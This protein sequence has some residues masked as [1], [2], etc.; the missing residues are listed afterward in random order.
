M[1]SCLNEAVADMNHQLGQ[2]ISSQALEMAKLQEQGIVD[3][4]DFE[5]Y[6]DVLNAWNDYYELSCDGTGI[7]LFTDFR[8]P[9]EKQPTF[10][11]ACKLGL[12]V[13]RIKDIVR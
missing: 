2:L 4:K 8:V 6:L 7:K 3:K 9:P 13:H 10:V 11:A 12:L 5:H 1:A